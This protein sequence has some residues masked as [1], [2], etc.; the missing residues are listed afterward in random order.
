MIRVEGD[1]T[2]FEHLNASAQIHHRTGASSSLL[3][4]GLYRSGRGWDRHG[5][6]GGLDL[7]SFGFNTKLTL[8]GLL[9][10]LCML[11]LLLLLLLS[12]SLYRHGPMGDPGV[13][14]GRRS[15]GPLLDG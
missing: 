3:F 9:M 7:F 8:F 5:S 1:S 14:D 10:L 15:H 6:F 12:S 2:R 11:L 13:A 4:G